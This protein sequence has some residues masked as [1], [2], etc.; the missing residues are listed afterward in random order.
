MDNVGAPEGVDLQEPSLRQKLEWES[1]LL[2]CV[3]SRHPLD[4]YWNVA[5][6]TYCP[7]RD[8]KKYI[9]KKVT[10]CG[11]V[12]ESRAFHQ[13]T[14]EMM[15]FLTVA[16]YTGML[17]VDLFARAYRKYGALTGRYQTL[18]I[19]GVVN[20]FENGVGVTMNGVRVSPPRERGSAIRRQ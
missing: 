11:R 8:L 16:D 14:G 10:I 20:G 6:E 3:M 17:G 1:E 15:K 9:G 5:W 18:Q 7:I 4:Y 2:G 13:V 12:V 19:E